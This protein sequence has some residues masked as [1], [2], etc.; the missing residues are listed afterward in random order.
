MS[1]PLM[2][3][4]KQYNR[5][6]LLDTAV[7]LFRRQGY[8]GTSTAEL[9]DELG[10]NRKSMYAEFGSK[11]ELFEATLDHYND[12]HLSRVL[13]PL[14]APDAGLDSIRTAFDGYAEASKGW[15]RGRGCLLCNTAVELDSLSAGVDERVA[16]YIQRLED[17]FRN[18]L[19]NAHRQGEL[20][21]A[22]NIDELASF[23]AMSIIGVAAA[24][25]A[26]APPTLIRSAC[27]V[28]TRLLDQVA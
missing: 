23:L 2:S 17:A 22:A 28:A 16:A 11:Q 14:E 8:H 21:A 19:T 12:H 4:T 5:E 10:I 26:E 18:A 15:A 24:I 9:V 1:H 25:R 6:D 7:E 3:R 27:D 13:A 20:P